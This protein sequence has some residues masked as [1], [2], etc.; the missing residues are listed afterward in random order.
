MGLAV[1]SIEKI[2]IG[3][4]DLVDR[5]LFS[6]ELSELE[7]CVPNIQVRM[8]GRQSPLWIMLVER[9]RVNI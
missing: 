1:E 9:Y 2:A 3:T 6:F 8:L 4:R 5:F 7:M